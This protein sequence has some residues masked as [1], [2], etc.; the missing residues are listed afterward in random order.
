MD[1]HHHSHTERKKFTHYLWEFLMLFLA[2]FCGFLAEYQLE[3]K[4]EKERGKQFVLMMAEDLA[5]D[6]SIL[7]SGLQNINRMILRLDSAIEL[8][9]NKRYENKDGIKALYKLYLIGL[10]SIG[11]TLTDRTSVQLK[12][13]GGM[14]LISKKDVA[15]SIVGYWAE[16]DWLK[17]LES[18][19]EQIRVKIKDQSYSI[20]DSRF[21]PAENS[22]MKEINDPVLLTY[23][24]KNLIEFANKLAHLRNALSAP[25]VSFII[26]TK[27]SAAN[28]LALIEKEYHLK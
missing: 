25:Y 3:H 27:K 22:S 12:N 15:D 11:L 9:R 21:Y 26:K 1:V 10:P 17:R 24:E 4:I 8:I 5:K 7:Q 20:F 2:V 13:A 16:F 23:D 19:F 14:R 28:L 6:T 18:L